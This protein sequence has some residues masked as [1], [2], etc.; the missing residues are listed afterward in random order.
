MDTAPGLAAGAGTK[1]PLQART[2]IGLATIVSGYGKQ[3]L[4]NVFFPA[5]G[6][7]AYTMNPY[8]GTVM[9]N[10]T[11]LDF[12]VDGSLPIIIVA[13]MPSLPEALTSS[14]KAIATHEGKACAMLC[15]RSLA[16]LR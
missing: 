3:E 5:E 6:T 15:C 8:L 13:L 4:Q 7:V 14:I 16:M 1:C 9:A 11:Y 10:P 2:C 12:N